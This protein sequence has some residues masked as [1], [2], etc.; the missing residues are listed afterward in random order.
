VGRLDDII[1]RNRNPKRSERTTVGIGVA[2]FL[3]LIIA[4]MTM[5]DLGIPAADPTL[6]PT[7]APDTGEKRVNDVL[8]R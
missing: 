8:L 3:L 5:T 6:T 1:E 2:L 7:R 4:L